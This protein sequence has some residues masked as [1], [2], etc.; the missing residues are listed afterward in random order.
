MPWCPNCKEEYREG[1]TVCVDCGAELVE[2]LPTEEEK[3][4]PFFQT[5]YKHVADKLV[6]YFDYSGLASEIKYDKINE[7][8]EVLIA[9]DKE[10]QAKKLYQ[11][12]YFVEREN[13]EKEEPYYDEDP[14]TL[15]EEILD[16]EDSLAEEETEGEVDTTIGG[17]FDTENN[18][19]TD[20]ED[21]KEAEEETD[22]DDEIPVGFEAETLNVAYPENTD[23][24]HQGA[25]TMKSDKYKDLTSTVYLF[26]FFGIGGLIVVMLNIAG[27][28]TFIQDLLQR[29]V[30][31]LLFLFFLYV[32]IST[33]RNAKKIKSEI[34]AE[35]KLTAEINDWLKENITD[36][37]F[38]ALHNDVISDE[39][40]Y[41][42]ATDTIRDMLLKEFGNQN[43]SYLD[44]LIEEYYSN[45]FDL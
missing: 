10:K 20:G 7:V 39:L 13:L 31:T 38:A 9:A 36:K 3:P 41:M 1:F 37:F 19:K 8:Y 40:N 12:F 2:E 26:L 42:K 16:S 17:A 24:Q 45:N 28:F 21:G 34:A 44:R 33:N 6:R 22:T 35:N 43:T 11:A 5:E 15:S 25:Y 29:I 23:H 14:P 18:N 4:I 27:V 32:G 30:F